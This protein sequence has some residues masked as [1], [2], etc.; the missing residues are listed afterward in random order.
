MR[1]ARL[2]TVTAVSRIVDESQRSVSG[3]PGSGRKLRDAIDREVCQTRQGRTKIIPDR[4]FEPAAGF[5][6]RNDCRNAWAGLLA[7]NVDPVTPVS[8]STR[9]LYSA[10]LSRSPSTD[11]ESLNFS[12]NAWGRL[13]LSWS[14]SSGSCVLRGL[15]LLL[16]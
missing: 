8:S 6:H 15:K 4:D 7:T 9:T 12:N 3:Q 10:N 16:N 2:H 13:S 11:K 1:L 5:N 14:I